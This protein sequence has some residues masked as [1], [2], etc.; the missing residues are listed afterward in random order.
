M[1]LKNCCLSGNNPWDS[2]DDK[3]FAI[4]IRVATK[5]EDG[6]VGF[7]PY[8]PGKNTSW[9]FPEITTNGGDDLYK[10]LL[11]FD[12][13]DACRNVVRSKLFS[14]VDIGKCDS[15]EFNIDSTT[16]ALRTVRYFGARRVREA[17]KWLNDFDP[18]AMNHSTIKKL[19]FASGLPIPKSDMSGIDIIHPS[20]DSPFPKIEN[21]S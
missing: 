8:N 7:D 16:I 19:K 18:N 21:I 1:E 3:A 2:D 6:S 14:D 15:V 4:E 9:I 13:Y 17:L 12:F 20:I 11:V 5:C 10:I